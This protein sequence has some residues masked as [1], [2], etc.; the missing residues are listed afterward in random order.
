MSFILFSEFDFKHLQIMTQEQI[1]TIQK[2]FDVKFTVAFTSTN[3]ISLMKWQDLN[4]S[5]SLLTDN[6]AELCKMPKC[7]QVFV[8]HAFCSE[9]PSFDCRSSSLL[10]YK[11]FI[12]YINP[13][14]TSLHITLI[15]VMASHFHTVS[16]SLFT[17]STSSHNTHTYSYEAQFLFDKRSG[18][19]VKK[20]IRIKE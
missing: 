2:I 18:K 15:P 4:C 7:Q 20:L 9:D 3:K 8:I 10:R 11:T 12:A 5:L 14:K 17:I 1:V 19:K 16:N 6:C 13:C